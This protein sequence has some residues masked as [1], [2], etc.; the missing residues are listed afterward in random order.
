MYNYTIIP[1]RQINSLYSSFIFTSWS[2]L[3][4]RAR[5][6]CY[7]QKLKFSKTKTGT[8]RTKN[9]YASKIYWYSWRTRIDLFRLKLIFFC[10]ETQDCLIC[11]ERRLLYYT[12]M[13]Y[14]IISRINLN[15]YYTCKIKVVFKS[16]FER[17]T[18]IIV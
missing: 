17:P 13:D 7:N 3:Y 11:N 5:C 10:Y 16:R 18:K 15:M 6:T 1:Y 14:K 12:D 2:S 9:I 8:F 4:T